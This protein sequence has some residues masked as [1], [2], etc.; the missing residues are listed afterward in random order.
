MESTATPFTNM[1]DEGSV[2]R[3]PISHGDGNYYADPDTLAALESDMTGSY[4][5]TLALDGDVSPEFNPNGSLDNIAG[6]VNE[7]RNVLGMMPHPERCCEPELGGVDGRTIFASM[8]KHA[9]LPF[10]D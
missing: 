4:S 8:L 2:L 7:G 6:I 3:V 5:A 9:R 1:A 10:T